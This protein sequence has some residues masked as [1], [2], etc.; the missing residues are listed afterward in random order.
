MTRDELIDRTAAAISA[1]YPKIPPDMNEFQFAS[2]CRA[3]AATVIAA[4]E[5][6]GLA[7]VER[8]LV[9]V[10]AYEAIDN[11]PMPTDGTATSMS[12]YYQKVDEINALLKQAIPSCPPTV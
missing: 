1:R 9:R 10:A 11:L 6:Q 7:I 3:D 12:L 8:R 5:A 4:I 2:R